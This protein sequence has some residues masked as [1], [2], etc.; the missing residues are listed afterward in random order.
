MNSP[1]TRSPINLRPLVDCLS[2]AVEYLAVRLARQRST[3][4]SVG[5]MM[6]WLLLM[7]ATLPVLQWMKPLDWKL[8]QALDARMQ[9]W[10]DQVAVVDIDWNLDPATTESFRD[11]LAQTI[12]ALARMDRPPA[13]LV[14]D[15][16]L[17]RTQSRNNAQ[18][19]VSSPPP[20]RMALDRLRTRGVKVF[21]AA[22]IVGLPSG[23]SKDDMLEYQSRSELHGVDGVVYGHA[24]FGY[25]DSQVTYR[26]CELI[27]NINSDLLIQRIM[28]ALPTYLAYRVRYPD[29]AETLCD[30][31]ALERVFIPGDRNLY[32]SAL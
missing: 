14:L 24:N 11:D 9:H 27:R 8:L 16:A 18:G 12:D 29:G 17:S 32:L 22:S 31:E 28:P 25:G 19:I 2:G 30:Q 3:W 7:V 13:M 23:L 6:V 5:Y 21:Q 10:P 4:R 1:R 20:L 15:M 26:P